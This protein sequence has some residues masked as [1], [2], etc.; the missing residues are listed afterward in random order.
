MEGEIQVIGH[1]SLLTSGFILPTTSL[2]FLCHKVV[3]SVICSD[4][5]RSI[6]I[7]ISIS[8]RS[9]TFNSALL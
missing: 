6:S 2:Y 4:S 7:F 8:V 5:F 1:E 9:L 3:Q